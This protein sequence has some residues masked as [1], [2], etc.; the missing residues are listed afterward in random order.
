MLVSLYYRKADATTLYPLVYILAVAII[1]EDRRLK[2]YYLPLN[3][4][5]LLI[6]GY[7]NL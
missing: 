3:I 5:R 7:H 1:V 6:A 4:T 2:S